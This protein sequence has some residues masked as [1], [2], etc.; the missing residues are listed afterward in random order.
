MN[1]VNLNATD[2]NGDSALLLL[3]AERGTNWVVI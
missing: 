2:Q 1:G 3:A